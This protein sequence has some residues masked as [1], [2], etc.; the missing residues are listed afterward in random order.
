[1][2]SAEG[3]INR[4]SNDNI[5]FT[6]SLHVYDGIADAN[7]TLRRPVRFSN[8]NRLP[9]VFF[10]LLH[11]GHVYTVYLLSKSICAKWNRGCWFVFILEF[12]DDQER[13]FLFIAEGGE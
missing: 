5:V 1:M 2:V 12:S 7:T 9:E 3:L 11:V 4:V 13:E 6:L 8:R 10:S